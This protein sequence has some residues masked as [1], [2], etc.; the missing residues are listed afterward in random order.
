M[1]LA[2]LIVAIVMAGSLTLAAPAHAQVGFGG[3]IVKS[4]PCACSGNWL[5]VVAGYPSGV[6]PLVFQP[7][8]SVPFAFGSFYKPGAFTLGTFVPGGVC[9]TP[10]TP[11]VLVPTI[12]TI[13]MIGTSP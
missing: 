4:M 11:C 2:S 10:G 7:G 3:A 12:G 6:S 9:L 5:V 8:A 1:R 13:T